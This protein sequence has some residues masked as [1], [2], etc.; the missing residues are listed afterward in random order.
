MSGG[1]AYGRLLM[2]RPPTGEGRPLGRGPAVQRLS[3]QLI[4]MSL[5]KSHCLPSLLG[6]HKRRPGDGA[7]D[8]PAYLPSE[9]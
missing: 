2:S 9:R 4:T 6:F 3:F 5:M 7:L 8:A 1:R